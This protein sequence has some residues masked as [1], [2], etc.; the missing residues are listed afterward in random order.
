MSRTQITPEQET[1]LR[2]KQQTE[3][4]FLIDR[5][6]LDP[7]EVCTRPER[8]QYIQRLTPAERQVLR[9]QL[10][11]EF[12]KL[13]ELLHGSRKQFT[14]PFVT[15]HQCDAGLIESPTNE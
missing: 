10:R 3:R 5:G 12:R 13:N 14:Q 9:S 1:K 2:V 6:Y 4:S 8:F 7:T 11:K 15:P